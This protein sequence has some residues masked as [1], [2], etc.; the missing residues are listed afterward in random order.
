VHGGKG[1]LLKATE[2]KG[3]S[4]VKIQDLNDSSLFC[5]LPP[6]QKKGHDAKEKKTDNYTFLT[7]C[8]KKKERKTNLHSGPFYFKKK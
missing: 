6:T 8:K 3:R 7:F 5:T 2:N 1:E 4:K